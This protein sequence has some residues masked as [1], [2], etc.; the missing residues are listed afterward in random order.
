[1]R[2][3]LLALGFLLAATASRAEGPF[4]PFNQA[5]IDGRLGG[6]VPMDAP[7]RDQAGAA[8]TLRQLSGGK[9]ILLTPVQHRCPNLCG[10]TLQGVTRAANA[11]PRR[12]GNDYVLVAFGID[13]AETP[14]DAALSV[15]KLTAGLAGHSPAGVTGVVGP[16]AS[17]RAVTDAL[18]YRY[19]WDPQLR[20]YAHVA[21]TAVLTP[22]GRLAAWLYGVQPPPDLLRSSVDAAAKGGL[23]VVAQKLLLLCYHYDP[24]SGRYG[25]LTWILLRA[26]GAATVLLLLGLIGWALLRGRR[27]A[28]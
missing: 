9:P 26:G 27:R 11:Q 25:N 2:R 15:Q 20:Q 8:V 12:P 13:P 6:R 23:G 14:A 16:Q 1:M 3:W 17:I 7:L 24:V 28:A 5:G 21:A 22:D 4:D 19:A 10:F 18:G